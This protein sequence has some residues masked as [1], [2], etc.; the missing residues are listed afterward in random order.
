MYNL[1]VSTNEDAWDGDPWHIDL[2]RCVREYTDKEITKKLGDLD[3]SAVSELKRLP[4]IFAYEMPN[5]KA[6]RF[7]FLRGVARRQGEVRIEYDLQPLTP[8]L[9]AENMIAMSFGLDIGKWELNRTH[10]AVKDVNLSKELRA[11]GNYLA[12]VGT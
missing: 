10:W 9:T 11:K 6:P 4:C 3:A 1:L 5:M 2:D 12:N 8:F 7:G